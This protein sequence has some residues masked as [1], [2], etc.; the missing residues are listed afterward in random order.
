MFWG[1]HGAGVGQL[2]RKG[3]SRPGLSEACISNLDAAKRGEDGGQS[4]CP[5]ME[6]WSGRRCC[7][8]NTVPHSW[9]QG[10]SWTQCCT[11]GRSAA[12]MDAAPHS[13]TQG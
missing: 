1:T 13:W 10:W 4:R 9:T 3:A 7:T 6:C 8:M 12:L 2:G 11:H 5:E